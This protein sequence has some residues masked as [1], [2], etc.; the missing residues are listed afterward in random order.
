MNSLNKTIGLKLLVLALMLQ[1]PHE[2]FSQ[3]RNF[4]KKLKTKNGLVVPIPLIVYSPETSAGFGFSLQYL[5]RFAGDSSSLSAAGATFLYTLRKQIIVNPNW[6]F[7]FRNNAWRIPGAFLYQKFP[8]AFY[9]IGNTTTSSQREEFTAQYIL[10][11]TRVTREIVKHL[12]LGMQYRLEYAFDFTYDSTGSLAQGI[13][14]G[15]RGYV[16]SGA[17]IA[18]F[19]DS[20]DNSMFP[21]RGWYLTF[22]N[23]FY[24][25]WLGSDYAFTN[26]KV[27]A[28]GYFNPFRSHVIAVQ[29]LCSFHLGNPPFKMMSLLGGVET[30]RGYYAGRY[31]DRHLIATQVEWRFPVYWRFMGVAFIGAGDVANTFHDFALNRI[32]Y[33]MGAGLRF[34]LDAAERINLR[35][36]VA[37]TLDGSRGFYLQLGEAF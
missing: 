9:G 22:S 29:A 30:M 17:G 33:A 6:E 31:R 27:D 11:K 26:F 5:Y 16:A 24:P 19:Y 25:R 20:R 8:E 4:F 21:F 1:T 35:F 14:R 10:F 2:C 12:H 3:S 34:T 7:N 15:S 36:D 32:K 28:R 37:F 18:A 13:I 23:H